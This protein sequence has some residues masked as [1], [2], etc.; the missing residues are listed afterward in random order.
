MIKLYRIEQ[1]SEI[2]TLSLASIYKQIRLGNFPK[3]IK[4]NEST[5]VWTDEQLDEWFKERVELTEKENKD[6]HP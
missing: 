3:G 1:V 5:N 6:E 4:I 2:T